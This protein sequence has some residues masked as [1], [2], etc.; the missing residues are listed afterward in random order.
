MT[1]SPDETKPPNE[2]LSLREFLGWTEFCCWVSVIL[3]PILI[4]WN[5]PSVSND[6]AVVRTG[7]VAVAA[8]GA[9]S[10]RLFDWFYKTR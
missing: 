2:E 4:W 7:L 9:I 5:G 8:V 3:T 1:P 6:Q 10:L